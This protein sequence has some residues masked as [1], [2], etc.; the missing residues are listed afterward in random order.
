[1]YPTLAFSIPVFN[2]LLDKIEDTIDNSN[3]KP[4]IKNAAEAAAEKVKEYYP[5]TDGRIY[6]IATSKL[7][8]NS[9]IYYL[10]Y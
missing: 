9:I 6:I 10:L 2:F 8:N 4:N 3:T 7:N 5:T 1:M